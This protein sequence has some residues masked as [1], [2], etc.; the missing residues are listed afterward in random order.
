MRIYGA[1]P[2]IENP[3]P[4]RLTYLFHEVHHVHK[5]DRITNNIIIIRLSD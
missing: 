5:I 3:N 4:S 1:Q 2:L